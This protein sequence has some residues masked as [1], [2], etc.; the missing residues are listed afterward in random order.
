MEPGRSS[1]TAPLDARHLAESA[2]TVP[3]RQLG[4]LAERLIAAGQ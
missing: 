4:E 2:A 1:W 3:V